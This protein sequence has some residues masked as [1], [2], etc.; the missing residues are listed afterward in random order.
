MNPVKTNLTKRQNHYILQI[1]YSCKFTE[2]IIYPG[3]QKELAQKHK[4]RIDKKI[5]KC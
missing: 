3:H 5:A 2:T 1:D 4:E